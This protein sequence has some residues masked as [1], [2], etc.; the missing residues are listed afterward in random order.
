[1]TLTHHQGYSGAMKIQKQSYGEPF[2][3]QLKLIIALSRTDL[4]FKRGLQ[5][6]LSKY[7][8]TIAQFGVLEAL[9]HL[10]P[11]TIGDI[12][13]KTLSTSGNMTVIIRNLEKQKL[14]TKLKNPQDQ[15]GFIISLTPCGTDLIKCVFIKHLSWLNEHFSP[16]EHEDIELL[17]TLL[18]KLNGI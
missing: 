6:F 2:D 5:V 12:I 11:L 4:S 10:G 7:N 17:I 14:V 18:K 8:M 15:R 16:L 9:Y 3:S 13:E 1:M